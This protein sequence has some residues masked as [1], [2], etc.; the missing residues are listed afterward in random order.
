VATNR[1]N[2]SEPKR[3][4]SHTT[5]LQLLENY[6]REDFISVMGM[7]ELQS[8]EKNSAGKQRSHWRESRENPKFSN[9]RK[10][11]EISFLPE[12]WH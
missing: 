8:L 2:V 3:G 5:K 7:G 9:V 12:K 4:Y 11:G 6:F 10:G 1:D